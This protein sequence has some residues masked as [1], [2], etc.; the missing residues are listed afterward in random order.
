MQQNVSCHLLTNFVTRRAK[1]CPSTAHENWTRKS[2][3]RAASCSNDKLSAAVCG[4]VLRNQGALGANHSRRRA[5]GSAV[6]GDRAS[7]RNGR[8]GSSTAGE[9][10]RPIQRV[11]NQRVCSSAADNGG[12]VGDGDE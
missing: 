10:S 5:G 12:V 3:P 6:P 2:R 9:H 7:S 4:N 11:Q 1:T 8:G